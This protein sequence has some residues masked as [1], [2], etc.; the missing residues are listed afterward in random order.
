M[1]SS[2]SCRNKDAESAET[3][4]D[5]GA[6]LRQARESQALTCDQLAGSLNMGTEQL[7]ALESGDLQR[8]PEPVFVTAMT[9]RVASKLH[10]DSDPLIQRLQTAL[11]NPSS[12][13]GHQKPT[14][15]QRRVPLRKR[16][17]ALVIHGVAGSERPSAL[18]PWLAEP[19]CWP[20]NGALC[21]RLPSLPRRS[22]CPRLL[23]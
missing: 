6:A 21:R 14:P 2:D 16:S 8:L 10:L 7:Q 19:W 1:W 5:I 20:A 3:L 12:R 13:K 18:Q 22:P 23:W 17:T 4:Q 11:G 15:I 9:R